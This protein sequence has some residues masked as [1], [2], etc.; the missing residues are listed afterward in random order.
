MTVMLDESERN[1]QVAATQEQVARGHSCCV[2]TRETNEIILIPFA[3]LPS[4]YGSI[5][6]S[7]WG[8][9]CAAELQGGTQYLGMYTEIKDPD[10]GI[11]KGPRQL[12]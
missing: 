9:Y 11:G 12:L 8:E 1:F 5:G 3:F 6:L 10:L 7:M 2:C 4:T